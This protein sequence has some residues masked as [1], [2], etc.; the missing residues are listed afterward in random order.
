[1]T[2]LISR[3][4]IM[5]QEKISKEGSVELTGH[6][7][8][9]ELKVVVFSIGILRL[10]LTTFPLNFTNTVRISLKMVSILFHEF[11]D[12]NLNLGKFN[13][14]LITLLPKVKE[15]NNIQQYKPICLFNVIYKIFTKALMQRLYKVMGRMINRCQSG[16]LKEINIMDGIMALHDILH[17]TRI[18]KK[19]DGLLLKLDF[20]KACYFM[21]M[22]SIRL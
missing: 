13:Y 6:F 5:S 18:R 11:H 22:S 20:E 3:G 8:V 7:T 9:N 2:S 12:Q 16:F 17:D 14:G 4:S 21:R 15:A 1:M 19:K 10:A